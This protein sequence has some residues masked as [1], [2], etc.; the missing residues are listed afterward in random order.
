MIQLWRN[1]KTIDIQHFTVACF[2]M[3]WSN[4][5]NNQDAIMEWRLRFHKHQA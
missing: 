1:F 2:G 5:C 3:R 4:V